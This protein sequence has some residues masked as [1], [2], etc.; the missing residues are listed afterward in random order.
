MGNIFFTAYAQY[1]VNN[2]E[3]EDSIKS[4][5][6]LKPNTPLPPIMEENEE[7]NYHNMFYYN[8]K[9]MQH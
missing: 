8:E 9:F 6:N 2:K 5:N 3:N 4:E 7:Y 1:L